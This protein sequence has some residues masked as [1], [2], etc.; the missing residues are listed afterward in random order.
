MNTCE[1]VHA[2]QKH[3]DVLFWPSSLKGG[4]SFSRGFIT[5]QAEQTFLQF[6]ALES[7]QM[8]SRTVC[9]ACSISACFTVNS[10]WSQSQQSRERAGVVCVH[11]G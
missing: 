6:F 8:L 7:V 1:R 3:V 2:E 5:I 4:L 11:D 10:G 9:D